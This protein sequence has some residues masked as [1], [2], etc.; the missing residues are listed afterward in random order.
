MLS[1]RTLF[2]TVLLWAFC[3]EP[4]SAQ[5][6]FCGRYP[7]PREYSAYAANANFTAV[8][9]SNEQYLPDKI[10]LFS[11]N[12]SFN[13]SIELQVPVGGF[14]QCLLMVT[15]DGSVEAFLGRSCRP[16]LPPIWGQNSDSEDQG[17]QAGAQCID[18]FSATH[19][20]VMLSGE[21]FNFLEPQ[22]I[23]LYWDCTLD[24]FFGD[25]LQFETC[26]EQDI[27]VV[28]SLRM[29]LE[30]EEDGTTWPII[31]GQDLGLQASLENVDGPFGVQAECVLEF[32]G[33][34]QFGAALPEPCQFV[35][36]ENKPNVYCIFNS[37]NGAVDVII[38]L[39]VHPAAD[40]DIV[41]T[42]YCTTPFIIEGEQQQQLVIPVSFPAGSDSSF[43]S[44]SEGRA[45]S[46]DD[47]DDSLAI[48]LGVLIPVLVLLAIAIIVGVALLI[49]WQRGREGTDMK[50]YWEK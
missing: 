6:N 48:L 36:G 17:F 5:K 24:A 31:P 18:E 47:D 21:L 42:M 49:L 23:K 39:T 40:E 26:F 45:E 11:P 41:V 34:V 15:A 2:L 3:L 35:S 1:T 22:N 38:P 44:S 46:E 12:I 27:Q 10:P 19:S 33:D 50:V 30:L 25:F 13:G 16:Y 7:L 37:P 29:G 4:L 20:L 28:P 9:L 8:L 14:A 32:A 43:N